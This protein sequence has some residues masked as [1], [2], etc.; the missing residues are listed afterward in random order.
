MFSID[1]LEI[2]EECDKSL[3]KNLK[4]GKYPFNDR[5]DW[6]K[7]GEEKKQRKKVINKKS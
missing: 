1:C 4:P 5:Y 7:N 6:N 2:L 3:R